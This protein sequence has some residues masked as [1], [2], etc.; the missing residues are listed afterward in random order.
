MNYVNIGLQ[1]AD[2]AT[3][4]TWESN[5]ARTC[6]S[7][8]DCNYYL[9]AI[10]YGYSCRHGGLYVHHGG[11]E[12]ARHVGSVNANSVL[13][14]QLDGNI[15]TWYRDG[16]QIHTVTETVTYPQNVFA[17]IHDHQP[18]CTQVTDLQLVHTSLS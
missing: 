15:I 8:V 9:A 16:T 18:A 12:S 4:S 17:T 13:R 6:S 11:S 2:L 10:A 1:R 3:W 5:I 7:N 14:I